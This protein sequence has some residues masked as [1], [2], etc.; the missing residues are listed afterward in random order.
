MAPLPS[1]LPTS[2]SEAQIDWQAPAEI[3]DYRQ[4]ANPVRPGLTEIGRAHV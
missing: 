3:F 4:A 1:P 2:P